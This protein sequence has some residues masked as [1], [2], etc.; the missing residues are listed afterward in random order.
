[1]LVPAI[2]ANRAH[3]KGRDNFS[4]M[5]SFAALSRRPTPADCLSDFFVSRQQEKDPPTRYCVTDY[6]S[7]QGS[8][9]QGTR[10]RRHTKSSHLEW[11]GSAHRLSSRF[12]DSLS[13]RMRAFN[14][15]GA[16]EHWL[17]ILD[18]SL[19]SQVTL[20]GDSS[21]SSPYQRSEGSPLGNRIRK[22]AKKRFAK[23]VSL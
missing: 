8:D 20:K 15:F 12:G 10:S 19:Q 6:L 16:S 9:V 18:C 11:L 13:L 3:F 2:L 5:H 22:R 17:P 7:E 14:Q 1:M 23:L 4:T 21:V